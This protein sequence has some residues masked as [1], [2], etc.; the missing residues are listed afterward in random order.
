M[1]TF[2]VDLVFE[3]SGSAE[4]DPSLSTVVSAIDEIEAL[5][6]GRLQLMKEN[7]DVNFDSAAVLDI[8][9]GTSVSQNACARRRVCL[10]RP[11]FVLRP[12]RRGTARAVTAPT[13]TRRRVGCLMFCLR[14]ALPRRLRQ[15]TR[16]YAY[17]GGVA[18]ASLPVLLP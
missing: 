7:P 1:K 13:L 9:F 4:N 11:A 10:R 2:K 17:A 14:P 6:N 16:P 12:P 3:S 18:L 15:N 5:K 8:H